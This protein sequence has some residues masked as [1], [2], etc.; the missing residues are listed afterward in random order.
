MK[1]NYKCTLINSLI[2]YKRLIIYSINSFLLLIKIKR[3]IIF[4]KNLIRNIFNI[5]KFII[6]IIIYIILIL[7]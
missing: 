4:I 2:F 1:I 3:F 7:F 6:K 5:E